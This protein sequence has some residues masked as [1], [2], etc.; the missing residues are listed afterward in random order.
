MSFGDLY[1]VPAG[2]G[3]PAGLPPVD[4]PKVDAPPV[5]QP[6]RITVTP[7]R[8]SDPYAAYADVPPVQPQQADPY[9][10]YADK[11]PPKQEKREIGAAESFGIGAREGLTFGVF[12]AI[13]GAI[14]A[15]QTDEER[16]ASRKAYESGHWPS[17]ASELGALVKG[18][19]SL[20]YEHLIAPALGI[21]TEKEATKAYR[22]VRD[23]AREEQESAEAQNPKSY[24]GGQLASALA[25]PIGGVAKA[26]S[27]VGRIAGAAKAGAIGGAAYGAGGALS[28]GQEPLDIA[29]SAAEGAGTGALLGS[30]GGGAVEGVGKI[31]KRTKDIVQ[32]A[33]KPEA[34]AARN[35][36][37]AIRDAREAGQLGLD[38]PTY[39][40]ALQHGMPVHNVDV[41]GGR[42]REMGRAISNLS[43]EAADLL[44]PVVAE[45]AEGRPQRIVD[46]IHRLFGSTL[47]AGADQI[48]L[49]QAA[50]AANRPMYAR[51]Y[52]AG[53]RPIWS[54]ELERLASSGA[55][56]GAIKGAVARGK[57]RAVAEGFGGFRPAVKVTPDGRIEFPKG[58]KGV[59][60][61]PDL[62]FWDY[63]QRELSDMAN[64]AARAGRKEEAS[65]LKAVLH[66][67]KAELD[68]QV[69]EFAEARQGAAMFF[70]A[71]NALEAGQKF[72]MRNA[73]PREARRVLAKMS[74]PERELFARGFADE[75]SQALLRNGSWNT[76]QRAFTAPLAREKIEMA[77]GSARARELEV[78]LRAET[79]AEKTK[80]A[81]LGNST[82]ARQFAG[83]Q[84]VLKS[85]LATGA[86]G[87]GGAGAVGAFELLK[88]GD[89]SPKDIIAGALVLGSLRGGAH[90][91][92]MKVARKMAE[93]L[94]SEDP[95]VVRKG[96][97]AVA[98]SPQLFG[99]LRR[100]TEAGTRVAAHD[101][102]PSGVGAGV[103]ALLE[104]VMAEDEHHGHHP[105]DQYGIPAQQ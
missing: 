7:D 44:E 14:G 90:H 32:G 30:A 28:E 16:E 54:P 8:A 12:P 52:A 69:P 105:D 99:A 60:T 18:L 82:T 91:I 76:I 84:R 55:V 61:Y 26:A 102:G 103:A 13:A 25:V 79:M 50:R 59:P 80:V 64:A 72:V 94:A 37:G 33:L 49:E 95:S 77:L 1:S 85:G 81:L 43:P 2:Q 58:P 100:G 47:D 21:K 38:A 19:G 93:L 65:T 101:I 78:V 4:L 17:A 71:E 68:R 51:A 53:S 6:L 34:V 22:E 56:E 66:D 20:G 36:G 104:H 46:T 67:L 31:A 97:Q 24:I 41:G 62:R 3:N 11:P 35:V 48:K 23:A 9:A 73:D 45:R 10:A 98:R 27:T 96:A 39:A 5:R 40:A 74:V 92:D 42:T 87:L 86:H 63:T 57:D 75:L 15:G 83:M 88:E 29:K 89:Y 70:G